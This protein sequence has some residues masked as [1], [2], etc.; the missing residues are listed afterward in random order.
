MTDIRR[1]NAAA[2][3]GVPIGNRELL[4]TLPTGL[5]I[6]ISRPISWDYK[7][8]PHA[9]LVGGTGSG[10]TTLL[11]EL[12]GNFITIIPGSEIYLATYKPKSEDFAFL[13]DSPYFGDYKRCQEIFDQFYLRFEQRLDGSDMNRNPLI[14]FF[15]EWVGFLLSQDKKTTDDLLNRMGQI[16]MLGRSLRV[17][18][19]TA[20][21]RP[22]AMFFKNG[23]RDN[24]NL[25]IAMGNL[26]SDGTRMI[27]PSDMIKT[28]EPCSEIGTGYALIGGWN[29]YKIRVPPMQPEI[30]T[31]IQ[32]Y[33]K[34]RTTT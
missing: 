8:Y 19:V 7:Q 3:S 30:E 17:I 33:F 25:I 9:L 31:T 23:S 10:K 11:K 12:I 29:L 18:V 27:F 4:H 24:F 32:K 28:L 26:S 16:L 6:T 13:G 20:M 14:L 21:Q 34:W 2:P 1:L 15:D 5:P 22:D